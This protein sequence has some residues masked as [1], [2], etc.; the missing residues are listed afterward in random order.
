M[1]IVLLLIA[2]V[3]TFMAFRTLGLFRDWLLL[4]AWA[5]RGGARAAIPYLTIPFDVDAGPQP[6]ETY[7]LWRFILSALSTAAACCFA[8]AASVTLLAL[9]GTA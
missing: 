6:P 7:A 1:R 4:R 9:F 5:K 3:P 2:A 8:L